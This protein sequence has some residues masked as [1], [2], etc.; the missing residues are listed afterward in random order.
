MPDN[1]TGVLARVV[2][3]VKRW[4]DRTR[5]GAGAGSRQ[6]RD[7]RSQNGPDGLPLPPARL[8]H[9]VAGSEDSAWFLE[10][11]RLAATSLRAILAR[12]GVAPE[13]LRTILDFGCGAGRVMR[14]WKTLAGPALHG[15]DYNPELIA[16][17]AANLPFA[18]FRV[19]RLDGG[20]DYPDGSFDLIYALSVFT[21]LTAEGQ[22]FWITELSRVLKPGGYLFLTTHGEYYLSQLS[23]RDQQ[24]FRDGR[25]VVQ[26]SKR[27]G[28]NDCAA[29][30]PESYVR[31]VLARHLDVVEF[32]PEGALGNPRQD[33]YVCRIPPSPGQMS[34]SA[35]TASSTVTSLTGSALTGFSA[36]S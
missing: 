35:R 25:L 21:H 1:R 17:C 15:T 10:G 2:R 7:S 33:A 30:H 18:T 5:H 23:P 11:G 20:V 31:Q 8:I 14:H 13:D 3:R 16:W 12:Q 34:P 29:F 36:V 22:T 24:Q 26:Q 6:S 28:S 9:L 27:A 4:S 32:I 19:N